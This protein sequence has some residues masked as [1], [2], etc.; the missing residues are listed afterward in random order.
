M[1]AKKEAVLFSCVD[2]VGVDGDTIISDEHG[3]LLDIECTTPF[4]S[5]SVADVKSAL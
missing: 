3:R 2:G 4:A 1:I 5:V